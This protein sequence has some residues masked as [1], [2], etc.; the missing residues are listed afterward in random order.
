MGKRADWHI[1]GL[2]WVDG[3]QQRKC[4]ASENNHSKIKLLRGKAIKGRIYCT[5]PLYVF[6]GCLIYG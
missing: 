6:R 4:F 5:P 3:S 1:F 2:L